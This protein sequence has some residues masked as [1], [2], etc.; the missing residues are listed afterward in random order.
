MTEGLDSFLDAYGDDFAYAFDNAIILNW[1]PRRIMARFPSHAHVLELGIGHGLT[2]NHFAQHF[3]E[4]HVI[5]GSSAVIAKFRKSYPNAPI[6]LHEGYFENFETD[7]RFDLIVMGFV[8]EH[9][10]DPAL[11]LRRF[12][13]FLKPNGKVV[14]TVPN[15]ESLHRQLGQAAGLLP[16]LM[17]LGDGDRA[18]GHV[19]NFT[20]QTL[21]SMIETAGYRVTS[22]EGLFLKPFTTSQLKSLSLSKPIID[23]LCKIGVQHPELSAALMVEAEAA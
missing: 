17:Q 1:Y 9:V 13:Q 14:M 2:C 22:S 11:I 16:D 23:A 7:R 10:D 18:L 19:R 15:A 6:T 4:Y 20:L 8:L 21:T 12:R 5:D 3:E